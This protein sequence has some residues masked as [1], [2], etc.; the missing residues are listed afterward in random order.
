MGETK[1]CGWGDELMDNMVEY[2]ANHFFYSSLKKKSGAIE[3]L[4]KKI[5]KMEQDK[6]CELLCILGGIISGHNECSEKLYPE[7]AKLNK[8]LTTSMKG[9]SNSKKRDLK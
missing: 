8:K 9:F 3:E 1:K 6:I 4:A 5:S 7:L 2:V